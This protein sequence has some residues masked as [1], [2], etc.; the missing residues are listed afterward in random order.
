[1][2]LLSD[3]IIWIASIIIVL[4]LVGG[5]WLTTRTGRGW[6]SWAINLLVVTLTSL[7][8]VTG[9][10]LIVNRL[11]GWYPTLNDI[12]SS[13]SQTDRK[14][15]GADPS[16]VFSGQ[17]TKQPEIGTLPPLP[18]PGQAQ[19]NFVVPTS[20]GGAG[21]KVTVLLPAGY[22]SPEAAHTRYPVLFAGHGFPGSP[23][24]WLG[25]VDIRPGLEA[26][27]KERKIAPPIVV[28][29]NLTPDGADTQCISGPGG[30][31]QMED[32][33]VKDLPAFLKSHL[34]VKE[35]RES[36]AWMGY[37]AG[38]WC[39][40]MLTMR[41]PD[42]W[43]AGVSLSGYYRAWY[44]TTPSWF[45]KDIASS[46]DLVKMASTKPPAVALLVQASRQDTQYFKATE[47]F[48]RAA[49]SPLSVTIALDQ[50]GGH[51]PNTWLRH[52]KPSL[53]WLGANVPGFRAP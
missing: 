19:Q 51:A 18:N 15:A 38:G 44:P 10:F 27:V 17:V 28:I 3:A 23:E 32:W 24:S 42:V 22:E 6:G 16:S 4:A 43:S 48:A 30:H 34:R 9:G 12:F 21:W 52:V 13:D 37:S 49:K 47:E 39:S 11:N 1:M 26:A 5:A 53:E 41:H 7:L 33:L 40:A 29:P 36:W 14:D 46:Y 35:G 8:V 25:G 2:D 50:T 20:T 31:T 45:T